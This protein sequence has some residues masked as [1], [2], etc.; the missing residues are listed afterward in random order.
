MIRALHVSVAQ[1]NYAPHGCKYK[2]VMLM[3]DHMVLHASGQPGTGVAAY[4]RVRAPDQVYSRAYDYQV[5]LLR[6]SQN[7]VVAVMYN[8]HDEKN[9]DFVAFRFAIQL[10][11]I[12]LYLS[13]ASDDPSRNGSV[14]FNKIANKRS[15]AD[16]K[17]DTRIEI[18]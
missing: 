18:T 13:S 12:V 11:T 5:S 14:Y 1:P 10:I 7:G 8:V 17:K 9:F 4:C 6:N 16:F 15:S 2:E 3:L